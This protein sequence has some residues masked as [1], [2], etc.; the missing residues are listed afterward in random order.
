[1]EIEEASHKSWKTLEKKG[2]R[3]QGKEGCIKLNTV[4]FWG[5]GK[6]MNDS[7]IK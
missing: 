1:M 3:M 7:L 6:S 5:K 4:A 2:D